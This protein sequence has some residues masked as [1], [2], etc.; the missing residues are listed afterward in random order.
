MANERI[1]FDAMH[2][3]ELAALGASR[4]TKLAALCISGGGIRSATFALGVIQGLARRGYL[5]KFH[6]LSTVSGGGYIGG[7][8]SAWIHRAGGATQVARVLANPKPED[9]LH[10]LRNYSNY[11][12]PRLGLF[13]ADTWTLASIYF[14]NLL[15]NWLIIIP[16]LAALMLVPRMVVM[17]ISVNSD[18]MRWIAMGYVALGFICAALGMSRIPQYMRER[19]A[20]G[21]PESAVVR[22]HVIP[23]ALSAIF[24]STGWF[25]LAPMYRL[26]S[27]NGLLALMA[28][29][30]AVHLAGW[31]WGFARIHWW[32]EKVVVS[33]LTVMASGAFGGM[34]AWVAGA[35]WL[36]PDPG[37]VVLFATL[38][39]PA[40]VMLLL[41]AGVI[42]VGFASS[43]FL[44]HGNGGEGF[45]TDSDREWW[46]RSGAW[47]MIAAIGWLTLSAVSLYGPWLI[48]KGGGELWT[49]FGGSLSG[50]LAAW[51][52]WNANTN[53]KGPQEPNKAGSWLSKLGEK[54]LA[55]AF[56]LTLLAFLSLCFTALGLGFWPTAAEHLDQLRR[57]SLLLGVRQVFYGWPMSGLL[58]TLAQ[59]W[60]IVAFLLL[61][62]MGFACC[63]LFSINR[64]SIHYLYRNRLI[65]AYLGASNPDR[66]AGISLFT[67]FAESDNIFL[68]SLKGQQ[69]VHV[70]NFA[71]NITKGHRLAWQN[72][73]A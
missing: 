36:W 55:P 54:L 33:W 67:G 17:A 40:L 61:T 73:K 20:H 42:F 25:Y 14:R 59:L 26:G 3:E 6:Y 64:F 2:E 32:P 22:W 4:G 10:W 18:K 71:L 19:G 24:L 46:A 21:T 1:A 52:G 12:S 65:R 50:V 30:A 23:V 39:M 66:K 69:P 35:K 63:A 49:A 62:A 58:S 38:G 37:H 13:S 28:F 48:L 68:P 29:G 8:L 45:L 47:L 70:L 57:F 5:D 34:L 9:P 43:S 44:R 16:F 72:R 7:W 31:G 60:Q 51:I 53:G 11:L 27:V 41:L 15:L 56:I